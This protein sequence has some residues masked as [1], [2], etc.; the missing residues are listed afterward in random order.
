[1]CVLRTKLGKVRRCLE[2]WDGLT[3]H[4]VGVAGAGVEA[5]FPKQ[6]SWRNKHKHL[7]E[8]RG[9]RGKKSSV[10]NNNNN[11]KSVAGLRRRPLGALSGGVCALKASQTGAQAG[12]LRCVGASVVALWSH[13]RFSHDIC[14]LTSMGGFH[15]FLRAEGGKSV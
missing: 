7:K 2:Q 5:R 15:S 12:G 13:G 11:E 10:K 9:W 6:Q 14:A 8:G 3:S 4:G 1:M